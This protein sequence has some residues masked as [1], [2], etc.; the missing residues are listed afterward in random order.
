M[1]ILSV[2]LLTLFLSSCYY[3]N[4]DELYPGNIPCDTAQ[5]TY[6]IQVEPIISA[7]CASAS[8]HVLGGT[9]SGNFQ[10]YS[11]VKSKVDNGS[12]MNRVIVQ[13]NMPPNGD[14]SACEIEQLKVW[15]SN[16]APNN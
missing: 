3:D 8:C 1:K 4:E 7:S 12:F 5:V 16:G 6:S 14:L 2:L 10:N 11:G 13:Q 9:G 15:L